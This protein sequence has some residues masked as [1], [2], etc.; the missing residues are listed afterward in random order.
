MV[1]ENKGKSDGANVAPGLLAENGR[2][3]K[4]LKGHLVEDKDGDTN[5]DGSSDVV[6]RTYKRR[7]RTKVVEDGLVVWHSAGQ[8]TNKVYYNQ[9]CSSPSKV[10]QSI[11][12]SRLIL[13]AYKQSRTSDVF[14]L[15]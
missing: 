4:K 12:S 14:S 1:G 9:K 15:S 3:V 6:S 2:T 10:L 13:V 11:K 5:L 8:S 7:K